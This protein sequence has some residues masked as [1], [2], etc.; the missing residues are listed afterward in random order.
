[1]DLI[2]LTPSDVC[3]HDT[4][5]ESRQTFPFRAKPY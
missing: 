3:K 1:M 5:D 4:I 2:G